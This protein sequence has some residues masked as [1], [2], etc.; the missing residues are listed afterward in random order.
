MTKKRDVSA[1]V[2]VNPVPLV[3]VTVAD[4]R[5][6]HSIITVGWAGGMCADPPY[7]GIA[8]RLDR[9]SHDII[10]ESREYAINLPTRDMLEVVDYCGSVSARERDKFADT[11]L[12]R[13]AATRLQWA[14]LIRECPVNLECRVEDILS[15]GQHDFFVG[16]VVATRAHSDWLGERGRICPLPRE[17]LAYS[18]GEY[19]GIEAPLGRR[20]KIF[21]PRA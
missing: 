3:L 9:F 16:R 18:S 4:R 11:G 7:V 8:V 14:S 19:L 10:C 15:L 12:H 6:R 1:T 20:G 13:E 21:R 17:Y 2:F 5:G